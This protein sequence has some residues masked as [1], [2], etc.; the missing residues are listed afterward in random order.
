ML[1][2]V[3]DYWG[4]YNVCFLGDEVKE[5]HKTI[6][7]AIIISISLVA[8]YLHRNEREH[9]GRNSMAG[10]CQRTAKS[11]F[12]ISAMM[13]QIYGNWAGRLATFLIMCDGF[14]ICVFVA[15][16]LFTNSV[17][18][19][20]ATEISLKYSDEVHNS[21]NSR[22]SLFSTLGFAALLF[23]FLSLVRSDRRACSYKN[24]DTISFADGGLLIWRRKHRDAPRPFKM[25]LYPLPAI[26]FRLQGLYSSY[27]H[28][29]FLRTKSISRPSYGSRIDYILC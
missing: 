20:N 12:L 10:V 3:Y 24:N 29:K 8:D 16:W 2:S 5:P 27:L 19:S 4:Y 14:R 17:C 21:T 11:H 26:A 28:E 13:E 6:P 15:S 1:I 23:C 7:R 22:M 9:I 18:R 25:W